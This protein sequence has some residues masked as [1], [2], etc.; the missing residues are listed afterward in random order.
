MTAK[1]DQRS[2]SEERI[3]RTTCA[4]HCGGTCFLRVHVR[5]NKITRIE[6]DDGEEPQKR[7]C[8]RGRAYRQR[9]YAPERTQYPLKRVGERGEGKFERI[10]WDEALETTAKGLKRIYEAYGPEA[11]VLVSSGGDT[12]WLHS[13]DLTARLL[14][15]MGGYTATWG[16]QSHGGAVYA[17]VSTFGTPFT[18]NSPDDLLNSRLIIM[19]GWNPAVSIYDNNTSWYMMQA[20]EKGIRII[21]VDPRYTPSAAVLA[22]QWIPIRPGTDAAM[23]NSMAYVMLANEI[24]DKAFVARYT[25]GFDRFKEYILGTNDHIP[26]TPAWAEKITGVPAATIRDLAVE[27]A[28]TKPAALIDGMAPGRTA[29]G[30]QFHRSAYAL[31]A[32]T[33]NIGIHG[34]NA[35]HMTRTSPGGSYNWARMG[36]PAGARMKGGPNP[37]DTD[38]PSRKYSLPAYETF[39]K[40]WTSSK[41]INRYHLPEAILKGRAA[42]YPADYKMLYIVN[43]SFMTQYPN[44]NKVIRA[45]K[46]LDFVVVQEQFMSPTAM[47]ADVLLPTNTFLERN[48]VTVGGAAPFYGYMNKAVEP[49]YESRSHLEIAV[50]LAKKLGIT[51]FTDKT[52]E[53]WIQEI[54]RGI[55]DIPDYGTFKE[56]AIHLIERTEPRV[57]FMKEIQD[58]EHNPFPTPSGKIEIYSEQLATMENPLLPAVPSYI[59][60]WESRNDPLAKTYPL[61][62]ITTHFKR[63]AHSTFETIP[64]LRELEAQ[65]IWMNT[66]DADE[67]SIKNGDHVRIFNDRGA[68]VLPARVT[69]RI[70][71]GV[72]DIPQGAW[73]KLDENGIDRGGCVNFLVNDHPLI[74]EALPSNTCL[75][76]VEH[77]EVES[78]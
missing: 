55:D 77:A 36:P 48:D 56:K 40:G 22:H 3:V 60:T 59:E 4:S 51:D 57:S 44:T 14:I 67:R 29:F 41:R 8:L 69:E 62:L 76:Q 43:A 46:A 20:K 64:W 27:Y 66:V 50:E 12:A 16:F 63:R 49:L 61:Q 10:T 1:N 5:D 78:W 54:V 65:A 6:T 31:T 18:N 21:S 35:A 72:V 33:G 28:T 75:V 47:Y 26:K 38:A 2:G 15:R 13:G 34:G 68:M 39:W 23:L 42:G 17:M 24:Y 37:V 9:V 52:E 32:M 58:P 45:L 53:E 25:V 7:A 71:P 19:W 70:M 73:P 74:K 30:E 11:V